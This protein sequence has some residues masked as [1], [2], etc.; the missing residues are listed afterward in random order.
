[1]ISRLFVGLKFLLILMTLIAP[2]SYTLAEADDFDFSDASA[3]DKS[4]LSTRSSVSIP[5][6]LQLSFDAGRQ[7]DSPERWMQLGPE[8]RLLLSTTNLYGYIK[9]EAYTRYNH[10]YILEEDDHS[11]AKNNSLDAQFNEFYWQKNLGASTLNLGLQKIAWGVGDLTSVLDVISPRD[12]RDFLNAKAKDQRIGQLI[13]GIDCWF[14]NFESS[15]LTVL[16]IPKPRSNLVPSDQ[17][18]YSLI[19]INIPEEERSLEPEIAIRFRSE[20]NDFSLGLYYGFLHERDPF[21]KYSLT[22]D[23]QLLLSKF[24]PKKVLNGLDL[25]YSLT[26][27]NLK[28]EFV[29]EDSKA[30]Q[31]R[32]N[33]AATGP[34]PDT[35]YHSSSGVMLGLEYLS[36]TLGNLSIEGM[37]WFLHDGSDNKI[38]IVQRLMGA[39]FWTRSFCH[40]ELN[41]SLGTSFLG[42]IKDV[43]TILDLQY[44]PK[45][46]IVYTFKYSYIDLSRQEEPF[47][48]M[49]GWD[50]IQLGVKY[51]LDLR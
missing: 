32:S 2:A 6:D 46:N 51:N 7:V 28:T 18:P 38:D 45:E 31:I 9:L 47:L 21:I 33:L 13:A 25:S 40:E 5:A 8:L 24:Y 14:A 11:F 15:S 17:H 50:R 27:L 41:M 19:S 1:M 48:T 12:K 22:R 26:P 49:T 36:D 3:E 20:W 35:V 37:Q 10:A 34:V 16:L 42:S 30:Y 44:S 39:F 4:L 43:I 29:Y 23:S